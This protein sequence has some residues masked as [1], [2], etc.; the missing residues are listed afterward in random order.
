LEGSVVVG[1]AEHGAKVRAAVNERQF[2]RWIVKLD[3]GIL[4]SQDRCWLWLGAL[5]SEGYGNFWFAGKTVKAHR[6]GFE[7]Y[8]GEI[9][10]GMQLDHLCRNRAC[11]NPWHLEIVT[12]QENA[13]RGAKGRLVTH[14][15]QGHE[16]IEENTYRPP[17]DGRRRCLTCRR[18]RSLRRYYEQKAVA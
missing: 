15:P 18:D 8:R 9:P 7:H 2:E 3:D 11:V 4:W 1:V 6:V 5:N 17:S 14:C 12:N 16:L 13:Q 10:E